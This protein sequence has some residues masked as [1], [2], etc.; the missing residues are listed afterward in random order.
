MARPDTI[1]FALGK[2]GV[3]KL[4]LPPVSAADNYFKRAI[5]VGTLQNASMCFFNPDGKLFVVR[6]SEL[7]CGPTPSRHIEN[8]FDNAK[9][10]GR[11]DWDTFKF[12]FFNPSGKLYAVTKSGKFYKG[13]EPDNEHVPWLHRQAT[14]IGGSGWEL[15]SALCFDNDGILYGVTEDKLLKGPPEVPG[16]RWIENATN[17]GKALWDN[18]SYFMGFSFDGNLWC[19][20]RDT[21]TLYSAPPPT[22]KDVPWVTNATNMGADYRIFKTM[23]FTLD[24]TIKTIVNL[25][26][27]PD[28]GEILSKETEMVQE[29]VYDNSKSTS[30]LKATFKV[31]KT[32]VAESSF[33]HQHGFEVVAGSELTVESG[34]P[35]ISKGSIKVTVSATTRHDWNF[36]ETNRIETKVSMSQQ[37]E[38][39]PGKC[40]M[41]SCV[42]KK[43]L[44]DVPY[45][46][47]IITV[48]GYQTTISG[49]WKGV[50]YYNVR[51]V[52]EDCN[53]Q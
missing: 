11:G 37:F 17:V 16:G 30:V 9:C 15:F 20:S 3:C 42:V 19:V 48:F 50:S 6:G 35:F 25:E 26:F 53:P 44:M 28:I 36:T 49:I 2:D 45:C 34:V 23:G 14:V 4:G 22:H 31:E 32:L 13:P 21:G 38:I 39:P 51:V 29:Q 33:S 40:I 8:W 27:L 7:Y 24:K 5:N 12:L 52:Q 46:A 18:Y 1:L 10:V 43:A 41:R 47:K